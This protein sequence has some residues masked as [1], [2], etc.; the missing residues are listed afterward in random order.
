MPTHNNWFENNI[1]DRLKFKDK[2][3]QI[4]IKRSFVKKMNFHEASDYTAKIIN[5]IGLPIY[6]SYSG[7]LDSEYV[8]ETFLRNKIPF[9]IIV[10][11]SGGNKEE[12]KYAYDFCKK[13]NISPII[14]KVTEIEML[15]IYNCDIFTELNGYGENAVASLIA[16]KYAKEQKGILIL[17]E[18]IIDEVD[19][20]IQLGA[21]EWDFYNDAFLDNTYYFFIHTPEI[22][23]SMITSINSENAQIFKSSLYNIQ[24]REKMKYDHYSDEY[25]K[26]LNLIKRKRKYR[27]IPK[28]Y[29]GTV[30]EFVQKYFNDDLIIKQYEEKIIHPHTGFYMYNGKI[31]YTREDA[32]DNMIEN[33]DYNTKLNFYY[34]DH[35]F[36]KINWTLEPSIDISL[37][38]KLRAQQIRD[39]YKYVILSFSGGSDSTQMLWSFVKN[40]IFVDEIQISNCFEMTKKL[41][42]NYMYSD[43][44]LKTFL[45]FDYAAFPVL[46]QISKLSP[47]TKITIYDSSDF[48]YKQI[49]NNK[50]DSLGNSTIK[51]QIPR[52]TTSSGPS[53]QWWNM[54]YENNTFK[55]KDKDSVCIVRGIEKPGLE[56]RNNNLFFTFSDTTLIATASFNKGELPKTYTT[57]DFFWTPDFPLIPIKQSHLIKRKLESDK[58]FYDFFTKNK[59]ELIKFNEKVISPD[60]SRAIMLERAYN[61]IIYPDWDD[62]TFVA[63]KTISGSPE[64]KLYETV[65]GK[66]N[67]RD[68]VDEFKNYKLSKYEKLNNKNQFFRF[69]SSIPYFIGKLEFN[70]G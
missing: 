42:R 69:I 12:I 63:P 47:K 1:K 19:D 32:F 51:H 24:Y 30:S 57:E 2:D 55:Y 22:L 50:F 14:L 43:K 33:K 27:P 60:R 49:S 29:L 39:K 59:T 38:Y 7:G 56:I 64:F 4:K 62:K 13:N 67:V 53:M 9:N 20:K 52:L 5:D 65:I 45:E 68:F 25:Y 28:V 35:I 48:L 37:L 44:D 36:G 21:N 6:I 23:Y 40:N 31:F 34:N 15:K 3:L 61:N 10:V 16:G 41:D 70:Y 54:F 17:G 18:H 66:S 46:Q 8:V 26:V 11:D 58:N